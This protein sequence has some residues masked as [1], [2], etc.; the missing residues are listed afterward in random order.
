MPAPKSW[1]EFE[2]ISL[3]AAKLRWNSTDFFRH[4]RL[5]QKQDGV[6]IW[7]H[8]DDKRHIL[9]GKLRSRC[10]ALCPFLSGIS[11]VRVRLLP[12][13]SAETA[14]AE[15][16]ARVVNK[17]ANLAVIET[18]SAGEL[19]F[20]QSVGNVWLASP[21]Q[22]YLD[23]LRGAPRQGIGRALAQGKD[24]I[25]MAKPATFDGYCDQYTVGCERVLVTLLRGLRRDRTTLCSNRKRTLR[26]CG[27]WRISTT[28]AS[29]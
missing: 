1:D 16:G 23:L 17:G 29:R 22:V 7:G 21:V 2:D 19:L 9:R 5:G 6:D 3:S 8:D 13:T 15:L 4:G 27:T 14:M 12:S 26:E 11:Q 28:G 20:R 24:W 10:T 25:L 18:K